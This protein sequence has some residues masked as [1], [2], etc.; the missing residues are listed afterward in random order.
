MQRS[1]RIGIDHLNNPSTVANQ[2]RPR[3]VPWRFQRAQSFPGTFRG[4]LPFD[5]LRNDGHG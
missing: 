5:D 3:N 1:N 4:P 2:D